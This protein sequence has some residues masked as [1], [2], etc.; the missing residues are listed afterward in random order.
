MAAEYHFSLHHHFVSFPI[1]LII[2]KSFYIKLP[3]AK[4]KLLLNICILCDDNT[5]FQ[6]K[7]EDHRLLCSMFWGYVCL[8]LLRLLHQA[9]RVPLLHRVRPLHRP[10][11]HAMHSRQHRLHGS[12]PS[13]LGSSN[14]QRPSDWKL[15]E[16]YFLNIRHFQYYDHYWFRKS[17]CSHCYEN[18]IWNLSWWN[19]DILFYFSFLLL[20]LLSR[21]LWRWW[22]W[23]PSTI[24]KR[25][26]TSSTSSS[27]LCPC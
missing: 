20:L 19:I 27:C 9:R 25:D 23:V 11:H 16:I 6:V 8:G 1:F 4:E 22:R 5:Y 10:V 18:W 12:R 21:L 26:G 14:G 7:R 2:T 24:S 15:C 17:F 13:R 3:R